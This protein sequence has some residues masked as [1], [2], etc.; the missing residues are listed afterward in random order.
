MPL[1]LFTT[2]LARMPM[3]RLEDIGAAMMAAN[4]CGRT[5]ESFMP[6]FEEDETEPETRH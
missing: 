1:T 2:A 4:P 5:F 3:P 6:Q